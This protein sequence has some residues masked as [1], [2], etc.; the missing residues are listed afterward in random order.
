[1]GFL[2]HHRR[3]I[4][5]MPPFRN[6]WSILDHTWATRYL[7]VAE[8]LDPSS[9]NLREKCVY[10]LDN[11]RQNRRPEQYWQGFIEERTILYK[12][13]QDEV[14]Y[15]NLRNSILEL[16][17]KNEEKIRLIA[18]SSRCLNVNRD[19]FD[20]SDFNNINLDK[21]INIGCDET[22][23]I[24]NDETTNIECDELKFECDES[25]NI[26]NNDST[27]IDDLYDNN[28]DTEKFGSKFFQNFPN[29]GN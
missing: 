11:D 19:N 13:E 24:E 20:H 14:L 1:M 29:F 22:T 23:N 6:N 10:F 26:E 4:V 15:E 8:F 2:F 28:R 12:I 16:K 9:K 18:L 5:V 25:T 7:Q 3:D 27:N 17:E 21:S